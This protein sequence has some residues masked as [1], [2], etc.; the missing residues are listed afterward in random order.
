[1]EFDADFEGDELFDIEDIEDMQAFMEQNPALV[2]ATQKLM[3]SLSPAEVEE[4]QAAETPDQV[5]RILTSHLNSLLGRDPALFA[6]LTPALPTAHSNGNGNGN[7]QWAGVTTICWRSRQRASGSTTK[8]TMMSWEEDGILRRSAAARRCRA[9]PR[10]RPQHPADGRAVRRR[11]PDRPRRAAAGAARLQRELDKTIVFV[12]HD[13]DEAFLL[14]DQVVILKQGGRIAQVGTPEEILAD[15]ASD[16]SRASSA[17]T[18]A[19]A[20]CTHRDGDGRHIA[21]RQRR[22]RS[23][24]AEEDSASELAPRQPRS[25]RRDSRSTTCG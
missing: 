21:R 16:S 9:R 20:R 14:G 24:V 15:P 3:A 19:T 18:R 17:S 5:Q 7:G 25:H 6:E 10:C 12:T 8:T 1:M 2:E 11:R 23:G 13:I 4:L 22:A